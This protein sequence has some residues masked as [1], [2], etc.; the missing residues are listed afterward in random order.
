MRLQPKVAWVPMATARN[1][2]IA[3]P[4]IWVQAEGEILLNPLQLSALGLY[5][6]LWS[7]CWGIVGSG[8]LC[9]LP[10]LGLQA[11]WVELTTGG[12][13]MRTGSL[14]CCFFI[15]VC[16]LCPVPPDV[17]SSARKP[18][19]LSCEGGAWAPMGRQDSRARGFLLELAAQ[20]HR[21]S[22]WWSLCSKWGGFLQ[23]VQREKPLY[24]YL[25]GLR[26]LHLSSLSCGWSVNLG[27]LPHHY[28]HQYGLGYPQKSLSY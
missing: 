18:F 5:W 20:G 27:I 26:L 23:R 12:G 9:A 19:T 10:S 7:I 11:G 28:Q 24:Y 14:P 15:P 21:C 25:C 1:S 8:Q 16:F 17:W 6:L 2:F 3:I 4:S 22:C 13:S